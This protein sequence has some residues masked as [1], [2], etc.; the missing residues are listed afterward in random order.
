MTTTLKVPTSNIDKVF[1]HI[2]EESPLI[3][4]Q[5][6]LII[7]DLPLEKRVSLLLVRDL[8]RLGWHMQSNY[9][10][11][12]ELLPPM[13]YEKDVIK[14]AM[15]YSRNQII[16]ANRNWIGNNID[17]ARSHLASGNDVLKSEIHPRIEICNSETQHNLF[18][19]FRYNWSSPSSDYVGRRIRLL[20]RDDGIKNSPIIGIAALGSSIIHIPD[21]DK[22]IGWDKETRSNRIIYMMD[23]YVIGAL[24]PYNYL[25]G[26]KLVSYVLASNELRDIYKKKYY[27]AKTIIKKRKASEL[28]LIMTTS[29][30]GQT[31][32]QYNRMKY[33]KSLLYRPIGTTAGYGSLH[34][35]SDTFRAMLQLA[36]DNQCN[37]SNNFGDGPNWRMRVIRAACDVM[38]LDS[39]IILRHSFRRGLFAVPLATNFRSFL[40]GKT[41]APIYRNLPIENLTEYWRK[42]WLSHRKQN[43]KVI[44]DVK[45]FTPEIFSIQCTSRD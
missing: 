4:N 32:S 25:L 28:A 44:N 13:N 8:L 2:L 10:K 6:P 17:L 20:V 31:S 37:I 43:E 1:L 30:Y 38:G 19:L 23:A 3:A 41:D 45:A 5:T 12:L 26:G 11:S 7:E 42:R 9:N 36:E 14:A 21:R 22:W 35:S 24:P 16:E 39:D 34:I 18:R 29:L 27:K 15:S 40:I 33:G